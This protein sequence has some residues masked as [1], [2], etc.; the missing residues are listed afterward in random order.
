MPGI[1]LLLYIL[2]LLNIFHIFTDYK[3]L[4]VMFS[5][6]KAAILIFVSNILFKSTQLARSREMSRVSIEPLFSKGYF[7]NICCIQCIRRWRCIF[8]VKHTSLFQLLM[9][10]VAKNVQPSSRQN[11]QRLQTLLKVL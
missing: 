1:S 8:I 4:L 5:N 7:I 9:H 6:T 10:T 11:F 2:V 3:L